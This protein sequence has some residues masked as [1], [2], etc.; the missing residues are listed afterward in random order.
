M[1]KTRPPQDADAAFV[2][3]SW[4]KSQ[5]YKYG[6]LRDAEYFDPY[7]DVI[8]SLIS[9]S[10]IVIATPEDDETTIIGYVVF[11]K[12]SVHFAYIKYPFRKMGIARNLR[13]LLPETIKYATIH[14]AI[15]DK[16]KLIFNPL[17]VYT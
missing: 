17:K 15:N 8:A 13:E 7:K 11:D 12:E 9:R 10:N 3:N 5:R 14:H 6:Q 2:L 4:L 1:F 16:M